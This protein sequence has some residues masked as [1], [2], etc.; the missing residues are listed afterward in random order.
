M[1]CVALLSM[2]VASV[3]AQ[4]A[5]DDK[6]FAEAHV[7]L[8]LADRDAETQARVLSVA[9]NLIKHYGGPDF[10]DIEIVAYG[11]GLSL[12]YPENELNERVES[13]LANGV[14][15]VGCMNTLETITRQTGKKP[16]L[17]EATIPVQTGVARLIER[18]AEG[19]VVI[20]P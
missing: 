8:Q 11:P 20:R 2:A 4:D 10:V 3:R 5:A 18:A 16:E 15:F 14:R 1:L 12:L 19:F 7:V 9:N 6:P 17:I 13:L